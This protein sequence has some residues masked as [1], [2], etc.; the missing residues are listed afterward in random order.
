[1]FNFIQIKRRLLGQNINS[2]IPTLSSG[3]LA[4]N[5]NSNELYYGHTNGTVTIAGSGSYLKLDGNQTV[6]G[7]KTFNGATTLSSTTFSLDSTIDFGG[8]KLTNVAEP[9]AS[10]DATTK[11]YV[12]TEISNL[13]ISGGAATE[14]LSSE[15]YNTFVKLTD[16]RAVNLSS[17]LTVSGGF[18]T[19]TISA[20]GDSSFGGNL[21]VTGNLS[22]LG[23]QTVV[24]TQTINISGV[25]T[26]IDVINNGTGTGIT[27]NQTGNQ[28]VAEFKDD[29]ATALIIKDG[30]NVGIGTDAPN[31]KLTVSGNVS[32][33]G[34]VFAVSGDYTGTLNIDG[35]TT[36]N[37]TLDVTGA[38]TFFSTVSA[39]GALTVDSTLTVG[40]STSLDGGNITTNGNGSISFVGAGAEVSINSTGNF[41]N[42]G[43]TSLS[44]EVGVGA[45]I[46]GTAGASQL[47]DFIIDGGL[48]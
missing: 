15:I 35:A 31:E 4:Y 12:D 32:A 36:L 10:T 30:G 24:N 28:D 40:S 46:T 11:N 33:S 42:S 22:V 26:Q 19:D 34:D 1:M 3:E 25:S 2:G 21:T 38:S 17:G 9:F 8:N 39:Q 16:D 6:S 27:V 18:S 23:T 47:I 5:E 13:N 45:N 48:F 20:S 7:D 37:S 14:A 44:G 41:N 29:G 43:T